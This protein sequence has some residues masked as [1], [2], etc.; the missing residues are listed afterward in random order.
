MAEEPKPGAEV[1][2]YC[3]KCK[4][5]LAHTILAV[6][7]GKIARVRCNTCQGEHAYKAR[8]PGVKAPPKPKKKKEAKGFEKPTAESFE[9]L[10]KG[11]DLANARRYTVKEK[12]AQGDVVDH[13]TFGIGVVAAIRGPEKMDVSFQAGL[14]TLMHSK[15][16]APG[17]T[18]PLARRTA[19][20]PAEEA[21]IT[22]GATG[23]EPA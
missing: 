3:T 5:V 12:F 22:T 21:E 8:P 20:E 19:A 16:A 23:T 10:S 9:V 18:K 7:K 13:P 14:K 11:K 1:D 2:S 6:N 4:M 17:L 15:G